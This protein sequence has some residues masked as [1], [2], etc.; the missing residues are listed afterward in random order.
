MTTPA[1]GHVRD[2]WLVPSL[3]GT[4]ETGWG[5]RG[6]SDLV[7]SQWAFGMK[8]V[9]ERRLLCWVQRTAEGDVSSLLPLSSRDM[10]RRSERL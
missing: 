7:G 6:V 1:P 3:D 10:K 5:G 9:F 2:E 8:F 4:R